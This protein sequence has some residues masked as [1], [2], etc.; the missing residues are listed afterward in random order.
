MSYNVSP[1]LT[2][3]DLLTEEEL[4][5]KLT[6]D[7]TWL[8]DAK[9]SLDDIKVCL[10][11]LCFHLMQKY[12]ANSHKTFIIGLSGSVASGKTT[13]STAIKSLLTYINPSLKV[14]V[15]S[16]DGF[17]LT[18]QLL[19]VQNI[20]KKKG[21]PCS[22]DYDRLK[23]FMVGLSDANKNNIRLEIPIHSHET[24]DVTV[25]TNMFLEGPD[26]VI[27]EGVNVLQDTKPFSLL[28][29]LNA[30]IYV[31]AA[32]DDLK[33]WY[34]A[35]F[36]DLLRAAKTDP[37]SMFVKYLHMSKEEIQT[38]IDAVWFNVNYKNLQ[39]HI[40]PSRQNAEFIIHKHHNHSL[41]KL[42]HQK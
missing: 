1:V 16:S 29:Y 35:R 22:Y 32:D 26:I 7:A 39:D 23:E 40:L 28:E 24:Y 36:Y 41:A 18:N 19:K 10:M 11:P 25:H 37:K 38:Q 21:F 15:V 3:Q 17:L 2:S 20:M 14:A 4:I 31:D 8:K 9:F 42:V 34:E 27:F 6:N 13:I 33:K 30:T 5:N 12:L